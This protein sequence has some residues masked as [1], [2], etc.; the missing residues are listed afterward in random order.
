MLSL[1]WFIR[2]CE[3]IL[4]FDFRNVLDCASDVTFGVRELHDCTNRINFELIENDFA[5]VLNDCVGLGQLAK[6][7]G[8][9][10]R[11]IQRLF[12]DELGISVSQGRNK[13]RMFTALELLGENK[14]VTEVALNLGFESPSAFIYAFRRFFGE[15]PGAF[16]KKSDL[17]PV[18]P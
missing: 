15:T 7:S 12:Q 4:F 2:V 1:L 6:Q 13:S 18:A 10:L 11:T 9:S 5:S 16:R 14:S 17:K 3:L 8:A